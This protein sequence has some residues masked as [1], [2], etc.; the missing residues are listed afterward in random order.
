MP[1]SH[2]IIKAE[3]P[4][5]DALGMALRLAAWF[6]RGKGNGVAVDYTLRKN[7]KKPG[8]A[9]AGFVIYTGQKTVMVSVG[10]GEIAAMKRLPE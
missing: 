7:V 4:S 10:E 2:V 9:P 1:G 8:G 5:S 3:H 6:S